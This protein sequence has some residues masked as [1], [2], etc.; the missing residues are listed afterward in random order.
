MLEKSLTSCEIETPLGPMI[1][2]ASERALYVLEFVGGDSRLDQFPTLTEPGRTAPIDSMEQELHAY[3][4]GKLNAFTTPLCLRGT[5]FQ[6]K[7]WEQLQKI[8]YGT[9][10][11]YAEL[12]M[13]IGQ[14]SACR[15]VAGANGANPLAI[16][17]PCHRVINA[18]GALG[19]YNSGLER[20]KGL[21]RL[22]NVFL[23]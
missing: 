21:L 17:I 11:S 10:I 14:P 7:V 9:T 22:E 16:I 2:L 1:A 19:G 3:F 12:A 4:Q 15:A 23:S 13:A 8:P 18:N 6:I 5:P 20:K